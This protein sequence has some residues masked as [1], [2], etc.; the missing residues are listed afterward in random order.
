M[1]IEQGETSVAWLA[2]QVTVVRPR[3][4]IE[5]EEGLQ[6]DLSE[7]NALSVGYA[8][9]I[10]TGKASGAVRRMGRGQTSA[11][12]TTSVAVDVGAVGASPSVQPTAKKVIMSA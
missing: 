2:P 9:C 12:G 7:D 4:K 8:Q 10:S 6:E 11:P 1:V 3:P 5:P